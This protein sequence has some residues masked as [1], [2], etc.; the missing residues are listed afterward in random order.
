M[1]NLTALMGFKNIANIH[2]GPK[3]FA[4]FSYAFIKY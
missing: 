2:G 3:I 1:K 4:H